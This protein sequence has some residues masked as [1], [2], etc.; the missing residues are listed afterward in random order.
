MSVPSTFIIPVADRPRH[1]TNLTNRI[2]RYKRNGTASSALLD[3]YTKQKTNVKEHGVYERPGDTIPAG[4][5]PPV[6]LNPMP[7]SGKTDTAVATTT[8]HNPKS[9]IDSG[10]FI[11]YNDPVLDAVATKAR[12]A[13]WDG[14]GEMPKPVF[15][16]RTINRTA[17]LEVIE[18]V[19]KKM[20]VLSGLCDTYRISVIDHPAD[21]ESEAETDAEEEEAEEEAEAEGDTGGN[22]PAE[23]SPVPN[24]GAG[25]PTCPTCKKQVT[26]RGP[27]PKA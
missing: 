11:I 16:E 9:P 23:T 27:C 2:A 25:K 3:Y 12:M 4:Y 24:A 1:I 14:T 13:S 15:T 21:S 7:K 22:T 19:T 17:T 18:A 26:H 10:S 20:L 8:L 6:A 5:M